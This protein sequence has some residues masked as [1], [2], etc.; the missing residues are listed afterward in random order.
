M[1]LWE[2]ELYLFCSGFWRRIFRVSVVCPS[3]PFNH[4]FSR[5]WARAYWTGLRPSIITFKRLIL[6]SVVFDS[7]KSPALTCT[8]CAR[9]HHSKWKYIFSLR[10]SVQTRVIVSEFTGSPKIK[11]KAKKTHESLLNRANKNG[12]WSCSHTHTAHR[13]SINF[14]R[15]KGRFFLHLR[16][17][18]TKYDWYWTWV[19]HVNIWLLIASCREAKMIDD[20]SATCA[21]L[22][23]WATA[24]AKCS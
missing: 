14:L 7:I 6:Y 17:T 3:S 21:L 10:L 16:R 12:L 8:G 19:W 13:A 5:W 22:C 2:A 18:N 24:T 20:R 23:T 11:W 15:R 4:F 1:P 9:R